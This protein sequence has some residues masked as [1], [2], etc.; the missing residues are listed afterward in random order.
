[1]NILIVDNGTSYIESLKRLV[2]QH[3]VSSISFNHLT[4]LTLADNNYD[5]IILSGGHDFS[6]VGNED[7]FAREISLL[8]KSV[9]PIL[10]ICLGFELIAV[11]FSAK[12]IHR[13]AKE[14]G[15]VHIKPVMESAL[16]DKLKSI[17][18]FESHRW[19]VEDPGSE[20]VNLANSQSG[21]EIIKHR[22]KD[23]Y[24]FQFHPEMFVELTEGDEIF[25]NFLRIINNQSI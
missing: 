19:V 5:L 7:L 16:F 4:D 12:L 20:L 6:V 23:I 9:V 14:K 17:S 3:Q 21:V 11:T 25:N 2:N 15:V 1:M 10:G 24:G 22:S 13:Q 18:V 8:R